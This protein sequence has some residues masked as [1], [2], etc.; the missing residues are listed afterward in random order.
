MWK[1]GDVE[2]VSVLGVDGYPYGFDITTEEGKRSFHSLTQRE[3]ELRKPQHMSGHL[4]RKRF[5]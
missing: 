5:P 3:T 4:L 1:V 2:P